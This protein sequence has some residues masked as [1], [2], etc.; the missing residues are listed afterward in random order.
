MS[1]GKEI[2]DF[3]TEKIGDTY[4]FGARVPLDDKN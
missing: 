4:V 3:A 1:T 2:V